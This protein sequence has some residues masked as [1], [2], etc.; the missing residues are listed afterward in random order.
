M[1]NVFS[2]I[3]AID[4][5]RSLL[6]AHL[7]RVYRRASAFTRFHH[8]GGKRLPHFV[9]QLASQRAAFVFLRADE[10]RGKSLQIGARFE[11]FFEPPLHFGL[12]RK[13]GCSRNREH[14]AAQDGD[15]ES[16]E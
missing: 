3:E 1:F 4:D 10:P 14:D 16:D 2:A 8:D 9:M 12:S 7:P 5:T 15:S 11:C 13:S 6:G